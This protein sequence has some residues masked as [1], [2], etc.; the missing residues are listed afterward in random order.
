L[1]LKEAV[2]GR[3]HPSTLT[4]TNNL[5]LVLRYQSKYEQAE[6]MHRQGL[7][8]REAVLGSERPETL[9]SMYCLAHLF[10]TQR[11]YHEAGVLYQATLTSLRDVLAPD[12]PTTL[13]CQ[14]HYSFMLKEMEHLYLER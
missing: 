8:L 11:R 4:S 6:E 5:A 13:R 2:L 1:G 9:R 14:K 10:H 7:R 3:E 12:H